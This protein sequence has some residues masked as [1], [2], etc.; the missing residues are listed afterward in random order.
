MFTLCVRW[1]DDQYHPTAGT[2][3]QLP[4]MNDDEA[5]NNGHPRR[6]QLRHR[7]PA[8]AADIRYRH[9][10]RPFSVKYFTAPGCQGIG[11][12][13]GDWLSSVMLLASPCTATSSSR[14][15]MKVLTMS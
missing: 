13:F 6:N 3:I 9:I 1:P 15:S 14:F 4:A 8:A 12:F 5:S 7:V 2:A 11:E 10:F